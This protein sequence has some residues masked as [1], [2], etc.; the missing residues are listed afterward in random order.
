MKESSIFSRFG[1]VEENF[2]PVS[3]RLLK[4]LHPYQKFH[5]NKAVLEVNKNNLENLGGSLNRCSLDS[6][7]SYGNGKYFTMQGK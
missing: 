1:M 5:S 6:R 4:A 7:H 3:L 2:Y